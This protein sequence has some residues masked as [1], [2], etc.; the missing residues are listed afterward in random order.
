M[1]T[2]SWQ[3]TFDSCSRCPFLEQGFQLLL[4]RVSQTQRKSELN[5]NKLHWEQTVI[6]KLC[7]LAIR[8]S[9][10]TCGGFNLRQICTASVDFPQGR[11]SLSTM[12]SEK[13][14]LDDA[15]MET[16]KLSRQFDI[17]LDYTHSVFWLAPL[18]C[19]CATRVRHQMFES[20]AWYYYV[21]TIKIRLKSI[22]NIYMYI[23]NP[24]PLSLYFGRGCSKMKFTFFS[25]GRSHLKCTVSW[26]TPGRWMSFFLGGGALKKMKG[27][28]L[29][30][31]R[32]PPPLGKV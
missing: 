13:C 18:H 20:P 21:W 10:R 14:L 26:G 1:C 27:S 16:R 32:P 2:A 24:Y 7:K 5:H 17:P 19:V 30:I 28:K 11:V 8:P 29:H 9:Y 22:H 12:F 15:E 31:L 25:G 4:L 6:V 3:A 23:H